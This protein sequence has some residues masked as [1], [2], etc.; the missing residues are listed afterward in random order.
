MRAPENGIEQSRINITPSLDGITE[1][2]QVEIEL[3]QD[4]L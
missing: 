2:H 1:S 4:F 3:F